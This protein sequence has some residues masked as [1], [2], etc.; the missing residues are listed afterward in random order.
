M[1]ESGDGKFA[2]LKTLATRAGVFVFPPL[3]LF[4]VAHILFSSQSIPIWDSEQQQMP[5]YSLLAD[6]VR[7]GTPVLW[8]P[9]GSG[10]APDYAITDFFL[11][12]PTVG[13]V[14]YVFGSGVHSYQIYWFLMW[15]FG[16]WGIACLGRHLKAPDWGICVVNAGFL[17]NGFYCGQAQNPSSLSAL[18][19]LP[20]IIWRLDVAVC[21]QRMMPAVEAGAIW[22]VSALCSYFGLTALSGCFCGLW[23]AGRILFPEDASQRDTPSQQ[24]WVRGAAALAAMGAVGLV[25]MSPALAGMLVE[26]KGYSDRAS[27][28]PRD[29]V[30]SENVIDPGS[31]FSFASPYVPMIKRYHDN[32]WPDT[33]LCLLSI[34]AGASATVLACV[35]LF[36]KRSAW[37]V[38]LF[39]A[40]VFCLL[41]SLG[42]HTALRGWLY[43]F[44]PPSRFFRHP[45]LFRMYW[46]FTLAVLALYAT[47]D[48]AESIASGAR[49]IF[50][51]ALIASFLLGSIGCGWIVGFV[52]VRGVGGALAPLD[53]LADLQLFGIWGSLF[54]LYWIASSAAPTFMPRVFP[55]ALLALACLDGLL[56]FELNRPIMC[57]ERAGDVQFWRDIEARHRP[58]L[59]PGPENFARV[60]RSEALAPASTV[61][62]LH[63]WNLVSK[64][65]V[66]RNY[67]PLTNAFHIEFSNTP[68]L[69]Q[70]ALGFDR[71]WFAP[72][73]PE[74]APTKTNF[75]AYKTR[76]IALG[77]API[78]TH[79][80]E[81]LLKM[82]P[83]AE[84]SSVD[85]SIATLKP[86]LKISPTILA[87]T[88]SGLTL[89]V[90]APESGVLLVT[91]RWARGWSATVNGEPVDVKPGNF[92]FRC[93][94]VSK[95]INEVAFRY[96]PF[97]F[98]ELFYAS[99]AT[100]I[101]AALMSLIAMTRRWAT[102]RARCT[103]AVPDGTFPPSRV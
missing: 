42:Y 78:V 48:M 14:A 15:V 83:A 63:N 91:E 90:E 12:S 49:V 96:R 62:M 88:T 11:L 95:G 79:S 67:S 29:I 87:Y 77:S 65:P 13:I 43:D 86:P 40:A 47:R 27:V 6:S 81:S 76:A 18:S 59:D 70:S 3:Y 101:G 85:G 37:R 73:A 26:I 103:S 35:A 66:F 69:E 2:S 44:F 94:P 99:A 72:N 53:G 58:T 7:A 80:R 51:G 50:R 71:I 82:D 23:V 102:D 93:V 1:L 38:W 28:L 25:I 36:S 97:G 33:N 16:A 20:W 55:A 98:P 75:A 84:A 19:F 54:V 5:Y 10:G 61:G 57:I 39:G 89:R 31:L 60:A 92:I 100:L 56:A 8:N 41:A 32:F 17:F 74:I 21:K 46:L 4:L 34:Y 45:A 52:I 24:R 9:Y 22:G 64:Q 68:V 30:I